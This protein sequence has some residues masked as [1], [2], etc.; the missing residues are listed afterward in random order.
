MLDY[1]PK[2]DIFSISKEKKGFMNKNAS[3]AKNTDTSYGKY[4]RNR[5]LGYGNGWTHI[6]GWSERVIDY[7]QAIEK[8]SH[9]QT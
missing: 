7:I 2:S 6:N 1:F 9:E 8:E 3:M 4:N 5:A